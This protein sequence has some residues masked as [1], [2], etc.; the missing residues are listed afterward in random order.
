MGDW[1]GDS[2]AWV[3]QIRKEPAFSLWVRQG[4][5]SKASRVRRAVGSLLQ[6]TE[7]GGA[8]GSLEEVGIALR[9]RKVG[10]ILVTKGCQ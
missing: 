4:E 7:G 10:K 2:D 3:A 6:N 1:T 5:K 8:Q 9:M